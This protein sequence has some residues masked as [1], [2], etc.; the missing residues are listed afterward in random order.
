MNF[1]T[2]IDQDNQEVAVNL[3]I[4]PAIVKIMLCN[5]QYALSFWISPT[6][7]FTQVFNSETERDNALYYI[8]LLNNEHRVL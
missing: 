5:K 8:L 7:S 3:D 6:S 1:Y 2:F 4:C